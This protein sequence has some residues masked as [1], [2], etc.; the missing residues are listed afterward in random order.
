[1]KRDLLYR[2]YHFP[3]QT[4]WHAVGLYARLTLSLR[5][6]VELL[7]QRGIIV[8]YETVR[9]WCLMFGAKY[10][11]RLRRQRPTQSERWYLDE[12]F[13]SI[14]GQRCYLWRPVAQDGDVIDVLLQKRRNARAAKRIFRKLSKGQQ[15]VP[16]GIVTDKLDS[17]R[18]AHRE[19]NPTVPHNTNQYTSNLCKASHRAT[20]EKEPQMKQFQSVA[21][22]R[23]F[24]GLHGIVRNLIN[25][26]RHAMSAA[27]YRHFRT[28]SFNA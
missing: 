15:T 21:T 20:L 26:G 28:N 9:R 7:A 1:M 24:L 2:G 25:W 17:Y 13:V 23:R 11:R 22:A 10:A 6:V 27:T 4:I 12:V 18:V 16:N 3:P 5:D 19:L 8:S 14:G